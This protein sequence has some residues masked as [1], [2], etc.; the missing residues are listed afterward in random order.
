MTLLNYTDA[1]TIR[2]AMGGQ[3]TV[4]DDLLN[5]FS[6]IASRAVDHLC[7]QTDDPA[8]QNYFFLEDVANEVLT[9]GMVDNFGHIICYPH[10]SFIKSV[11]SIAW[12]TLPG[13]GLTA[14]PATIVVKSHSVEVWTDASAM[15]GRPFLV[16][17]SY[18][19]GMG[20]ALADLDPQLVDVATVLA[21]RKY[22][23]ERSGMSDVVGVVEL[24]T[25]QYS[26]G[27][28][29]SVVRDLQPFKRVT[30]WT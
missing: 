30:P 22:K 27:I 25:I 11:A 15:R 19:G 7:A 18:R 24:G 5:K 17:I 10:K 9:N 29:A 23:E 28:P 26:S 16:T 14:D 3:E 13:A 12:S 20:A 2:G 21:I 6:G 4:Q 1:A 8:C